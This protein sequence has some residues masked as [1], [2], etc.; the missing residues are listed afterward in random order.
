MGFRETRNGEVLGTILERRAAFCCKPGLI[1][2]TD[3]VADKVW[4]CGD[5]VRGPYPSTLEGAVLS[6]REVAEN[7]FSSLYRN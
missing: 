7:V 6:G 2:P 3:Q 5:Y 1:R 4:V